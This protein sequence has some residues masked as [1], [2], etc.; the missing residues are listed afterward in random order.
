MKTSKVLNISGNRYAL[1]EGMSAKDIQALVGFLA[2]FRS[3][4]S[5][6]DYTTSSYIHYLN[7]FISV[8]LEDMELGDKVEVQAAAAKS[9][10]DWK[11]KKAEK[12]AAA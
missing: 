11:T 10:E 8:Q 2:M 6:Y 1:P 12:E 7:S 9:Y 4:G 3:V 5:E